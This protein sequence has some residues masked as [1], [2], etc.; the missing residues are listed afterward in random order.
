[1]FIPFDSLPAHARLWIYQ[2]NRPVTNSEK[3]II[4]DALL[5]FTQQWLVH[6]EPMMASYAIYHDQFLILAADEGYNAASGCSIDGSVRALK[7]LG[8]QLHIDFFDRGT[9]AFKKENQLT[10]IPVASLKS[11]GKEGTWNED[12]LTFNN[13]VATKSEFETGW[14]VR[15][16][17]TWLKRYIL[18]DVNH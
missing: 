11:A 15:A 18:Q 8:E 17:D 14:I 3:N 6:G 4:S 1:M 16:G 7:T 12:T 5:A 13:L 2:A 9:V 10:L